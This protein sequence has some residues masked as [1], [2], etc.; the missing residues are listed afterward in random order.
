MKAQ[1]LLLDRDEDVGIIFVDGKYAGIWAREEKDVLAHA[2]VIQYAM[3]SIMKKE[4]MYHEGTW[5]WK[6]SENCAIVSLEKL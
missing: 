3:S 5:V 2:D 4:E 6:F 1:K